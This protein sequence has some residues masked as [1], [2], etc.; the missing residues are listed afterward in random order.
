MLF[1]LPPP[2][3]LVV[4]AVAEQ[5]KYQ[6]PRTSAFLTY[7]HSDPRFVDEV[8]V[9]LKRLGV[10]TYIDKEILT[11]GR[12]DDQIIASIKLV[13]YQIIFC[14]LAA[15]DSSFCKKEVDFCDTKKVKQI[16]IFI[17]PIQ[18]MDWF[19][20]HLNKQYAI[21]VDGIRDKEAAVFAIAKQLA[22]LMHLDFG[23]YDP[24]DLNPKGT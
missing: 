14:S 21:F 8:N 2:P 5:P 22:R 17:D 24:K 7:A 19:S 1:E 18:K 11:V 12:L 6:A 15:N 4:P 23:L 16:P 10:K 20:F 3:P 9:I 13:E